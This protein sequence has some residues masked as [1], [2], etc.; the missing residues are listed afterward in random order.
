MRPGALPSGPVLC[1]VTANSGHMRWS[2]RNE[3][4][5]RILATLTDQL[6]V[7]VH[8]AG[9]VPL[10]NGWTFHA[11]A[12]GGALSADVLPPG[13]EAVACL[14]V[15]ADA[16]PEARAAWSAAVERC[17][18]HIPPCDPA[19]LAE[20]PGTPVGARRDAAAPGRVPSGGRGMA[21]RRGTVH[22]LGMD[23]GAGVSTDSTPEAR[24]R[25]GR[26]LPRGAAV[27]ATS[28][29]ASSETA[30]LRCGAPVL[31]NPAG[32]D[33]VGSPLTDERRAG[34]G[35]GRVRSGPIRGRTLDGGD[36]VL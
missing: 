6:R 29:A 16:S 8:V 9:P 14:A 2:P 12:D 28:L 33:A 30:G 20:P 7:A 19:D 36:T 1:H 17:P 5:D 3:V 31:S 10:R 4:P 25:K 22:R 35:T 27:A 13:G 15:G 26:I 23:R 18:W 24:S 32:I 21:R 11:A 34:K